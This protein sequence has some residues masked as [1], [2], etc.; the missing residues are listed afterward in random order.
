MMQLDSMLSHVEAK[1]TPVT[2]WER[3]TFQLRSLPTP[4]RRAVAVGALVG[5]ALFSFAFAGRGMQP[6]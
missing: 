3:F 5:V 6:V 2:R 4:K 1:L